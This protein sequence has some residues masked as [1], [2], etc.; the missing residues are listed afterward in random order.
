MEKAFRL[1][2]PKFEH[3]VNVIEKTKALEKTVT[4]E[5]L[6]RSP[7]SYEKETKKKKN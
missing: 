3:I 4:M 1:L 7:Q 6:V 2:D 5:Q